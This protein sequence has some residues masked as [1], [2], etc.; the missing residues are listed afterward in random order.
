MKDYIVVLADSRQGLV[1]QVNERLK[2]GYVLVG[3]VAVDSD[4]KV[5]VLFQAMAK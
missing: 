2:E 5:A 1:D 3:G 4:M